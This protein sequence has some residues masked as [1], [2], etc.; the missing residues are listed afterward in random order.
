MWEVFSFSKIGNRNFTHSTL[1]LELI[2]HRANA[3]TLQE[4]KTEKCLLRE[5][6]LFTYT[7]FPLA[8]QCCKNDSV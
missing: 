1:S 5:N 4:P 3:I 6:A 8:G 2:D 7:N